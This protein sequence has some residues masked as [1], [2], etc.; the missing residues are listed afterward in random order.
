[1]P[2]QGA[3][4]TPSPLPAN[5]RPPPEACKVQALLEPGRP[6]GK[7]IGEGSEFCLAPGT[8]E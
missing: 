5:W 8:R 7:H 6:R 4:A 1:M 3:H 2:P